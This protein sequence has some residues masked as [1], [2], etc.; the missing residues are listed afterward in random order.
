MSATVH[1][2]EPVASEITSG[3][4]AAVARRAREASRLLAKL[5]NEQRNQV[6]LAAAEAMEA[7]MP[8][9]LEANAEDC[10]AA[11]PAVKAGKMSAA[12]LARLG[13][14]RKLAHMPSYVRSV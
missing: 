9:I 3:G 2:S 11:E 4:V 12:M 1:K 14:Q 13:D 6:L 10:R 5:S 8:R 7:S